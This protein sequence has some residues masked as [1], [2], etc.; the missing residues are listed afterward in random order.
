MVQIRL[1]MLMVIMVKAK[2]LLEENQLFEVIAESS[3]DYDFNWIYY[4]YVP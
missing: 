4:F 1:M 3:G 2:M